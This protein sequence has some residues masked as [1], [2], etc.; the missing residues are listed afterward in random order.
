LLLNNT[1]K[2]ALL[3]LEFSIRIPENLIFK[4]GIKRGPDEDLKAFAIDFGTSE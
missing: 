3:E 2:I 1:R 4:T